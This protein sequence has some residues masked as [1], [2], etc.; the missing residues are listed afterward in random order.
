[1]YYAYLMKNNNSVYCTFDVSCEDFIDVLWFKNEDYKL[2]D[3][4]FRDNIGI[5]PQ[6]INKDST[7]DDY[8]WRYLKEQDVYC[9]YYIS[10]EEDEYLKTMYIEESDYESES[11]SED[12]YHSVFQFRK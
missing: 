1:M 6:P 10:S 3:D 4:Y 12:E 5:L 2:V 8:A 7:F 9:P 11:E